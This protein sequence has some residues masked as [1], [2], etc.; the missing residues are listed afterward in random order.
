MRTHYI[1]HLLLL[2][3]L[4][5]IFTSCNYNQP[6]SVGIPNNS[7]TENLITFKVNGKEV[8][9]HGWNISRFMGNGVNLNV[10]SNMHE[11]KRM[12]TLNLNGCTSGKYTLQN[13]I[14]GNTYSGYGHYKPDYSD[15]RNAYSFQDGF[16]QI[17]NIDTVKGLLNATFYGTVKQNEEVFSITE[18]R[19][20]NGKLAAGIQLY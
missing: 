6:I 8:K 12:L 11:D 2:L 13:N 19:I 10:T 7:S 1:L 18:G 14:A 9:T 4:I 5:G 16:F 20:T 15:L 17:E 3:M